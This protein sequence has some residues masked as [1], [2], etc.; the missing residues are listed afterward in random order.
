MAFRWALL[1][2]TSYCVELLWLI[3]CSITEAG[4]HVV[5]GVTSGAA[6]G[7]L[8]QGDVLLRINGDDITHVPHEAV[9]VKYGGLLTLNISLLRKV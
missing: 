2:C 3:L 5:A 4:R 9:L 7:I 1:A 8:E 6:Q